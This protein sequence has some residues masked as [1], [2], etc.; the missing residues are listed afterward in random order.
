MADNKQ[1]DDTAPRAGSDAS[2]DPFTELTK[3]MGFDPREPVEPRTNPVQAAA[4]AQPAAE[5]V[6][7]FSIDLEREL[8]G[9]FDEDLAPV[10]AIAEEE[11]VKVEIAE[12]DDFEYDAEF[13]AA[14][15]MDDETQVEAPAPVSRGYEPAPQPFLGSG[16]VT[17]IELAAHD[18]PAPRPVFDLAPAPMPAAA[19][20]AA[21]ELAA[22]FDDE[23]FDD[24]F[25]DEMDELDETFAVDEVVATEAEAEDAPYVA[26]VGSTQLDEPEI[27]ELHFEEMTFEPQPVASM[28][29]V[30]PSPR[31][32]HAD[33][34]ALADLSM[35]AD[36]DLPPLPEAAVNFDELDLG[37]MDDAF[38]RE[39]EQA[40]GAALDGAAVAAPADDAHDEFEI[41]AKAAPVAADPDFDSEIDWSELDDQA[42]A[43][44]AQ[45]TTHAGETPDSSNEAISTTLATM[46]DRNHNGYSQDA[47][48]QPARA[49]NNR[50]APEIDT[51]ELYDQAYAVADDLDLPRVAYDEPAPARD[52]LDFEFDNL[53]NDMS[54]GAP[55]RQ[56][57]ASANHAQAGHGYQPSQRAYAED[58]DDYQPRQP[59]ARAP[60]AEDDYNSVF[61][62]NRAQRA[63][64]ET[65]LGDFEFDDFDYED[66][67]EP[68]QTAAYR[69]PQPKGRRSLVIAAVAGAVALLG[70]VGVMA[71]TWG[72]G[73]GAP[74]MIAADSTPF[75][76]RPENPGGASVPN[77]NSTVYDTVSRTGSQQTSQERL[78]SGSEEPVDLPMPNDGDDE[79]AA[80]TKG[81]D[82]IEPTP[83]GANANDP[84]AV[85][86][87][88]VRTMIVK[89]D[90]TLAPAPTPAA[91]PAPSA[92]D[93]TAAPVEAPE[94]ITT[95]ATQPAP[96][97]AV[98]AA[99]APGGWSVQIA[100]QP[101]EDGANKSLANMTK[102]YS[103]VIGGRSAY[104]VKGE[105]AGKGTYWRVRVA[106][107]SRDEAINLCSDLKGAGG[108]CFVTR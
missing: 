55:A 5:P 3:I 47:W 9:G 56:P 100:S 45:N 104:I 72:G 58:Y 99:P 26:A 82:R 48:R 89:P 46:T 28:P 25:A 30:Q 97:T 88:K 54:R 12:D 13:D 80:V 53:L 71:M 84:L 108:S 93:V 79:V 106:A 107:P 61:A 23:A 18:T 31:R 60:Q 94:Q 52:D 1:F 24:A 43:K 68:R 67:D 44:P 90:G 103:S 76:V 92:G 10:E 105:V 6:D 96:E 15:E 34:D 57:A 77:Q 41:A 50:S 8:L 32:A 42:Q 35:L 86:P 51:T 81:E 36:V 64:P 38:D 91:A 73:N 98:A 40:V 16:A 29:S 7:D 101:S 21:P 19:V 69:Q 75:K 85:S 2:V 22:D 95:G 4:K 63:A 87:R 27:E 49:Q 33:L 59:T 17:P 37:G 11:T 39:I 102:R 62:D 74:A 66:E 65:D 20:E 78:V 14:F 83:V 70:G